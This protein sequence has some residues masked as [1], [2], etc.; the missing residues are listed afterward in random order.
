M[1]Q[2]YLDVARQ[3]KNNW[4]RYLLGTIVILFFWFILGTL[5]SGILSAIFLAEQGLSQSEL[6]EETVAS[7]EKPSSIQTYLTISTQFIFFCFGIFLSVK[8]LHQ[9]RFLTLVGADA[10]I[11]WQRFFQGFGAWFLIQSIFFAIHLILDPGNFELA[12]KPVQW[13]ILLALA[14]ILIP[15]QTS[16]EELFFR[17]YILQGFGLITKQPLILMI[18]N[19][20]L[21]MLPHLGNP[22]VG[23]GFLWM[24][25]DYFA[26]GVFC[27]L[28]TLKDN[29]L[30]L[31][32]GIHAAHNL[33]LALFIT[34]K[35]S[36]IKVP[37]VW[38][39]KETSDPKWTLLLSL[40]TYALSYLIFF[41]LG[42]KRERVEEERG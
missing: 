41:G 31:A 39:A 24:A 35:D 11:R 23:R 38:L 15:I 1:S 25:L 6:L 10:K 28:L 19:G 22:E 5:V 29:R 9:R 26:F 20:V 12:F 36:V 7:L 13:L 34:T 4:W 8:W 14:L 17:G 30:E 42:R 3:G 21:F 27:T 33:F 18:I 16:T 32:I 40:F 37:S 2:T